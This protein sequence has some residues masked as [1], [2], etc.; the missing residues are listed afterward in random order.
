MRYPDGTT[1][2]VWPGNLGLHNWPPM[3]FNPG[4]GLVYIPAIETGMKMTDKGVDPVHWQA[5]PGM[6]N[7]G[8]PELYADGFRATSAASLIAW[9]PVRKAKAWQVT[10]P[11]PWNGGALTTAGRLVFQGQI[12]GYLVARDAGSGKA[13]WRYPVES[14]AGNTPIT[15]AWKGRQY[16][17]LVVG[18]PLGSQFALEGA[19]GYGYNFRTQPPRLVTFALDGTGTIPRPAVAGPERPLVD[20]TMTLDP[21]KVKLGGALW[22]GCMG[23]HG[24][25]ARSPGSAPD[26]RASPLHH[27]QAAFVQVVR[28][29]ALA[30]LGMPPFPELTDDQIEALREYIEDRARADAARGG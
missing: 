5:V 9:D 30:E 8:V 24:T 28:Q 29:G 12:D 13:V 10:T 4:T 3:A 23:C 21:A 14:A 18:P 27:S 11:A 6:L 20:R 15:F 19:S 17:S 1:S 7:N 26:L 2:E 16:V 22:G 25:A